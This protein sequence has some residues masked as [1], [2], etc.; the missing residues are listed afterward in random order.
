MKELQNYD[1][2]KVD[3]KTLTEFLQIVRA[4]RERGF[5]PS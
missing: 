4:A 3:V 5:I 1:F 2:P